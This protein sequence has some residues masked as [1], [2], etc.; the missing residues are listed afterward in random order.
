[1]IWVFLSLHLLGWVDTL[2]EALDSIGITAGKTRISVWSV[3]KML[4]TVGV[5]VLDRGLGLALAG[6]AAD[7]AAG[8]RAADMRIGIAKFTQAFLVGLVDPARPQ[9]RRASTSRR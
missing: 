4:V 5:F 3:L 6:E 2:I 7:V 1:M 9:R 8:P